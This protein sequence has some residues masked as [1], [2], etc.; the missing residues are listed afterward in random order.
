MGSEKDTESKNGARKRKKGGFSLT[1]KIMGVALLPLFVMGVI[2]CIVATRDMTKAM[3]EEMME[4]IRISAKGVG[5]IYDAMNDDPYS[6]N[7]NGE[8]MK[9]NYNISQNTGLVDDFVEGSD[10]DAT[11]FYGDT[12]MATTL[13]D[14]DTGE[15]MV[16]TQAS[17]EVASKVIDGGQTVENFSIEINGQNYYAC[18]I[19]LEDPDGTIIGM[20]FAGKPSK[21]VMSMIRS[22]TISIVIV[23]IVIFIIAS[24]I[25]LFLVKGIQ[26]GLRAAEEAVSGLSNGDLTTRVEGKIIHRNDELGDMAKGVAMLMQQLL[27]VVRNIKESSETLLSAGTELS[28]MAGQTSATADDI[29]KAVEEISQGAISQAEE[30]ET[31]SDEIE[32]MGQLIEKIVDNVAALNSNAQE[33]K[34]SSDKSLT[35]IQELSTSNERS[36]EAVRRISE[37]VDATN[38][39]AMKISSAVDLITSIAEETNLLSLNASIEAARAGEQGKGFAVVA[40]QIQKLAEQSNESAR[41]IADIIHELLEDS[42]TS[43][44]VMDEVEKIMNEQ[45]AKLTETRKQFIEVGNGISATSEATSLIKSQTESCDAA[46]AKVVDVISNLSAISQQNA[47]STEET[48]ASMEELNATINLLAESARQLQELSEGMEGNISFF[49]LEGQRLSGKI[50]E[51]LEA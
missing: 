19:P 39:S 3:Q 30:I 9:G 40:G 48:T 22:K 12:R 18:Y 17:A 51:K 47:A 6:V 4:S 35:I 29:S 38:D 15:K 26:K 28:D 2:V 7:E 13:V 32:S 5:A 11:L 46:R 8:L 25:I 36:M 24:I 49:R 50:H 37:Q 14:K 43:I 42:E 31:A 41:K 44:Q 27:D 21:E 34:G 33:I 1:L 23:E 16:G 20:S 45:Q 10:M